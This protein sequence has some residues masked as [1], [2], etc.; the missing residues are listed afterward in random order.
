MSKNVVFRLGHITDKKK[1]SSYKLKIS[2]IEITIQSLFPKFQNTA[3]S[4]SYNIFS[5]EFKLSVFRGCLT[6][7]SGQQASTAVA[8]LGSVHSGQESKNNLQF[9]VLTYLWLWNKVS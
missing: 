6:A 7:A 2:I 9:M 4:T 1:Y 8:R 5:F 3:C